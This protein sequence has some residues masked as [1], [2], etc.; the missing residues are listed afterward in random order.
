MLTSQQNITIILLFS[1]QNGAVL[2][3]KDFIY[4]QITL[5]VLYHIEG[6]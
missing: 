1:Q 3:M 4:L 5:T 2:W 6:G